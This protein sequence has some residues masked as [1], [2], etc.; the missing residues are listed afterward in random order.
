MDDLFDESDRDHILNIPISDSLKE[1]IIIWNGEDKGSYSVKSCYR[2]L[3][4]E[5]ESTNNLHW[6]RIWKLSIPPKVKNFVWQAC[7]NLL[8]TTDNLRSRRVDC[9]PMCSLCAGHQE[10]VDHLLTNCEFAV[11]CFK[12]MPG[13]SMGTT[14]NFA[15]W[16]TWHLNTLDTDSLC[17]LLTTCWKIWEARNQKV[18]RK[19][20]SSP[21]TVAEDAKGFLEAWNLVHPQYRRSACQSDPL[22][23]VCPSTALVPAIT[24]GKYQGRGR[25]FVSRSSPHR[26]QPT[27]ELQHSISNSSIRLQFLPQSSR[28]DLLYLLRRQI[29]SPRL[30]PH[31]GMGPDPPL[32]TEERR[33]T[34]SVSCLATYE[35]RRPKS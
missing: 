29:P 19:F 8:P 16:V 35:L 30:R 18:W 3:R 21:I 34:F 28:P 15:A 22:W 25:W 20:I 4:G 5:T 24:A 7:S 13:V 6:T 27:V 12:N 23:F 32:R 14:M 17:L 9:P 1:D 10:S 31:I 26:R 11:N 33:G 2:L